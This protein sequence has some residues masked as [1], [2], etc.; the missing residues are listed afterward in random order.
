MEEGCE[1]AAVCLPEIGYV[2]QGA[3]V[4]IAFGDRKR[5][6]E[7]VLS[8]GANTQLVERMDQLELEE[9]TLPNGATVKLPKGAR[10]IVEGPAQRSDVK[11]ANQRVYPRSLWERLI[12]KK[13][14]YVQK[15]IA[16]RGMIGHLEHPK[17]GRTDLKESAILTLSADLHED[18]TV[19]SK[20]EIL[21]TPNGNI[22]REL[23][24]KGVRWGVSSR[25]NGTVDDSGTVS[26]ADYVLK[27]WDAVAAPSTPGAYARLQ[28]LNANESDHKNTDESAQGVLSVRARASLHALTTL[29]ESDTDGLDRVRRRSLSNSLLRVIESLDRPTANELFNKGES[30]LVVQRAV[31]RARE[32]NA[33]AGESDRI[34]EAIDEA[35]ENGETNE[36]HAGLMHV[37]ASLQEQIETSVQEVEDLRSRLQAAESESRELQ[38]VHEETLEQFSKVREELTR[39]RSQRDL[40][41]ELLAEAMARPDG[42]PRVTAKVDEMIADRSTL[43]DYRELLLE[44]RDPQ[45]VEELADKLAPQAPARD[46]SPEP[47]FASRSSLPVG[48]QVESLDGTP[49]R[50]QSA[51]RSR[52][53]ELAEAI[54]PGAQKSRT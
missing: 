5:L 4:W 19:W 38:T 49:S 12:A 26:E 51:P 23:T 36:E 50:R 25:G 10:W 54:T 52:G 34:D 41:N 20:F 16:E 3:K 18:G 44:A 27:T 47:S 1:H 17:D 13:D 2:Q 21:E 22:L 28:G 43:R 15:C 37:V 39:T 32:L 53:V 6:D 29:V 46:E 40:A 45:Q 9:R 35:L 30:W 42:D 24:A 14:S 7:S 11:N 48:M 8:P 31:E 33:A